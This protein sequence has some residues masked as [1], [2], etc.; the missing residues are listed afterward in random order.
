M[1]PLLAILP[2]GTIIRVALFAAVGF[3]IGGMFV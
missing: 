2:I 3:V 1:A